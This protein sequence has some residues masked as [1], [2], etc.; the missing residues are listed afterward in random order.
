QGMGD[1]L[2]AAALPGGLGMPVDSGTARVKLRFWQQH[3]LKVHRLREQ[4]AMLNRNPTS[5]DGGLRANYE[6]A[7]FVKKQVRDKTARVMYDFWKAN[8]LPQSVYDYLTTKLR[9]PSDA[10]DFCDNNPTLAMRLA[11]YTEALGIKSQR[12]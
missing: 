7:L 11:L 1:L 9:H 10:A 2:K 5:E 3:A 4:I 8:G 6:N 12:S